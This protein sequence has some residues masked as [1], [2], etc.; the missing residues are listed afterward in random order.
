M[1]MQLQQKM[2]IQRKRILAEIVGRERERQRIVCVCVII[3]YFVK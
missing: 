1:K 3:N 2:L